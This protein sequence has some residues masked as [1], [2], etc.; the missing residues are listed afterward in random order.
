VETAV[1]VPSPLP[2]RTRPLEQT[3][4][5]FPSLFTSAVMRLRMGVE[6]LL[7]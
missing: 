1:K 5:F 6:A 4:S 7:V 2:S 3:M